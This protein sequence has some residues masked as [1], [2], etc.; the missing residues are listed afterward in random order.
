MMCCSSM[1]LSQPNCNRIWCVFVQEIACI[2]HFNGYLVIGA[3][4]QPDTSDAE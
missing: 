2:W 3:G 4:S 1:P